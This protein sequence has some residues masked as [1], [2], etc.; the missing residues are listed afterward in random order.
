M[1]RRS[2]HARGVLIDVVLEAGGSYWRKRLELPVA[3]LPG[4]SLALLDVPPV[5]AVVVGATEP[6]AGAGG[7]PAAGAVLARTDLPPGDDALRSAGW[8]CLL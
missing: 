6:E 1:P 7:A 8:R 5:V 2:W 3:P 4:A